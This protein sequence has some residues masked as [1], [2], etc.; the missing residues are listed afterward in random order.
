MKIAKALAGLALG[1]SLA[2]QGFGM[3]IEVVNNDDFNLNIGGRIQ[4]V[5][6]G[7]VVDDPHRDDGRLY[8]FL[9][10]AR[11][12]LYG[13][14]QDTKFEMQW[15]GA[16]ED[17]NG[18]NAGLTLLDAY[19]DVPV[20]NWEGTWMRV[21][22]Y[23]VPYGRQAVTDEALMQ[24]VSPSIDFLGVNLGRDV[25]AAIHTYR[26]KFAGVF[27]VQTGGSRDVPLRFLPEQ[28]GI[29]LIVVRMGYND[30]LDADAFAA[31]QND[32]SPQRVTKAA[33][34]N[35]AYLNDT[36]IGHS[37]VLNVRTSDKT[38]LMNPN[39]NPYIAR[40][41]MVRGEYWQV[42]GDMAARGPV[43]NMAWT[44]EAEYNYAAYWNR[45]GKVHLSGA[46]V[47]GGLLRKKIEVAIR[48][49]VLFP[50]KDFRV[51][52]RRF[53]RDPIQEVAPAIS[54]YIRGHD[55][56]IVLD[57]PVLIDVPVFIENNVGAYV[58]TE[59]VDQAS[60]LSSAANRV[61]RQTVPEARIMYQLAF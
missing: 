37:T 39:W 21:G 19:F 48:Y 27:N 45:Y 8:L 1:A 20:F 52:T 47:Q 36:R 49:A 55:N 22:Q 23:K 24:M 60:V 13:R 30:G 46:R 3:G 11:L 34:I 35:G 59:Q 41:P 6:Y 17:V 16:A 32:L 40:A 12:K 61:E 44:A 9:K 7:Q 4:E 28:L 5:A 38:L 56:K 58:A 53:A 33:F 15:V 51:G 31:S 43:G 25:G 29:P 26:G 18:S 42:G 54:Y 57:F 50:D 2:S 14:V 10:Q